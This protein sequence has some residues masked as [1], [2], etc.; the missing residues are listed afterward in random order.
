M[1][2][3][4]DTSSKGAEAGILHLSKR[5]LERE[6]IPPKLRGVVEGNNE[7]EKKLQRGVFLQ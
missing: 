6:Y 4:K 3:R 2:R 5:E 1:T 7:N